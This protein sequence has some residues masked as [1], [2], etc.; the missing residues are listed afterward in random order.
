ML[1]LRRHPWWHHASRRR[2][3]PPPHLPRIKWRLSMMKLWGRSSSTST[4]PTH[5]PSATTCICN[6]AGE[7]TALHAWSLC[8]LPGY[9]ARPSIDIP[10]GHTIYACLNGLWVRKVYYCH[11]SAFTARL[12]FY[13]TNASDGAK[14]RAF[15]LKVDICCPPL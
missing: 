5:S 15:R 12:V 3:H 10:S 14:M 11:A 6:P 13:E 8:M 7:S 1:R 4:P 2:N 9:L